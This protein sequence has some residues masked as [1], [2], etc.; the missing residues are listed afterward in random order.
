MTV[1]PDVMAPITALDPLLDAMLARW[2]ASSDE[3]DR[4]REQQQ[5]ECDTLRQMHR[6]VATQG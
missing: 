3:L 2:H 4:C 6:P 1:P 5:H